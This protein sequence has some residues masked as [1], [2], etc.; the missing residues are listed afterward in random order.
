MNNFEAAKELI[1]MIATLSKADQ[2]HTAY[3]EAVAI[4]VAALAGSHEI[5]E[6]PPEEEE[7]PPLP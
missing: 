6:A 1:S 5:V 7:L 2:C 3:K 4:A